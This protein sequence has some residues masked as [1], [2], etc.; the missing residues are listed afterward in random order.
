MRAKRINTHIIRGSMEFNTQHWGRSPSKGLP[1]FQVK[2]IN[3]EKCSYRLAG[4]SSQ[5]M[6]KRSEQL[7]SLCANFQIQFFPNDIVSATARTDRRGFIRLEPACK[8]LDGSSRYELANIY[9]FYVDVD[10]KSDEER[11]DA[12]DT[13]TDFFIRPSAVVRSGNGFHVYW[14]IKPISLVELSDDETNAVLER[15][16]VIQHELCRLMKYGD[17]QAVSEMGRP[18]KTPGTQNVK[19][20]GDKRVSLKVEY[21]P[22]YQSLEEARLNPKFTMA[23]FETLLKAE[24]Y[25]K[26]STRKPKPQSDG[27]REVLPKFKSALTLSKLSQSEVQYFKYI[28]GFRSYDFYMENQGKRMLDVSNRGSIKKARALFL[29]LGLIERIERANYEKEIGRAHV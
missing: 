8:R 4:M 3:E 6:Y 19:T 14:A 21:L 27:W 13:I 11:Y 18:M 28:F 26:R 24:G 2:I 10:C 9:F 5:A 1:P 12:F 29:N 23:Q 22:G 16:K 25:L 7:D 15:F 20:D 17:A